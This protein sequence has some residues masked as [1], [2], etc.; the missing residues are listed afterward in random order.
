MPERTD[1]SWP[2]LRTS[3]DPASQAFRANADSMD[4]LVA[5][6]RAARATAALGGPA[7]SRERHVAR[8]KLL[9]RARVEMLLH[10]NPKDAAQME[11]V[12]MHTGF[13]RQ[14][15]VT[16]EDLERLQVSH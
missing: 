12:R 10:A 13:R 8:G 1:V 9:P 3:A 14:I 2:V 4:A 7:S 6:L 16:A 15:T 5:G 11:Y